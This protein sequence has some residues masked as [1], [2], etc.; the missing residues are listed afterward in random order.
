MN[1][2]ML[3][4]TNYGKASMGQG[5]MLH[6]NNVKINVFGTVECFNFK[7]NLFIFRFKPKL[8]FYGIRVAKG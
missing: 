8:S 5:D 2:S 1:N 3:L 7:F 6:G 4:S